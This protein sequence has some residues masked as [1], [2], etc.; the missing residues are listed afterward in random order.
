[1]KFEVR[2]KRTQDKQILSLD[3]A[4]KLVKN[5]FHQGLLEIGQNVVANGYE[6]R[7]IEEEDSV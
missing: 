4:K 7:K 3:E 1:M 6:F 5:K 2:N